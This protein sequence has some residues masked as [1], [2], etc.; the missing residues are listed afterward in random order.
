MLRRLLVNLLVF[1][2]LALCFGCLFQSAP[3]QD[4]RSFDLGRAVKVDTPMVVRVGSFDVA[5]LY[6]T[7]FIYRMGEHEVVADEYNRWIQLPQVLVEQYLRLAFG[8]EGVSR[9]SDSTVEIAGDIL[10]F[11]FDLVESQAHLLVDLELSRGEDISRFREDITVPFDQG[12]T[13]PERLAAAMNQAMAELVTRVV[14][15][16]ASL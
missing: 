11:E 7:R 5:R 2:L 15:K 10:V 6:G 4:V 9:S 8:G 14:A 12:G 16:M 13:T 1:G 3:Y